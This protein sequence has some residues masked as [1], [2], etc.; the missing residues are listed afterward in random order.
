[1]TG[2]D[3]KAIAAT[4]GKEAHFIGR[5]SPQTKWIKDVV[6]HKKSDT[7]NYFV[8]DG[9]WLHEQAYHPTL[10]VHSFVVCPKL[11]YSEESKAI[12]QEYIRLAEH[13]YVM[14]SEEVF[15]K[16]SDQ[17]DPHGL[18]SICQYAQRTLDDLAL[19]DSN[20]FVIL[21]GLETPGNIGTIIR[22]VDGAGADGVIL[23]KREGSARMNHPKLIRASQCTCFH[24]PMVEATAEEIL[25]WLA[26]HQF[27]TILLDPDP[28][29]HEYHELSYE[30]RV[31][32]V[33]GNER[34][35][36]SSCWRADEH[37]KIFIPMFGQIDSLN[38]GIATSIVLYEASLKQ[39][40]RI[41]RPT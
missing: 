15:Q 29:A 17:D 23:C 25:A 3:I 37:Q 22:S 32:I 20:L 33:A 40:G 8:I 38:V 16:F 5:K 10:P 24:V 26:R 41:K 30:K 1:M 28:S 12:V 9:I 35:G 31:A 39:K 4:Y 34:Y 6:N 11:V 19:R 7:E 2:E 27:E 14:D 13:I 36:I 18:L 21:D